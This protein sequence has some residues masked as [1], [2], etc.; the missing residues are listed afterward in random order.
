MLIVLSFVLGKVGQLLFLLYLDVPWIR[1]SGVVLYVLTWPM[2]FLG[3][4]WVGREYAEA[5]QKYFTYKFYHQKMAAGA[6]KAKE[7]VGRRIKARKD[8]KNGATGQG[9]R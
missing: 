7:V 2:L 6:R 4:W 8:K 1:W 5:I 9:R 3:I